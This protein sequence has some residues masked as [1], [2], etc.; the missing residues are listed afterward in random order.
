VLAEDSRTIFILQIG[1]EKNPP[2]RRTP[3]TDEETD[4]LTDEAQKTEQQFVLGVSEHVIW[5]QWRR[6]VVRISMIGITSTTGH[7]K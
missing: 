3:R 5:N 6:L 7:W 2:R 1:K 4:N